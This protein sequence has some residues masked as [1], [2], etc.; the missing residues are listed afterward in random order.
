[1]R[2]ALV[3]LT[4]R[5]AGIREPARWE[6]ISRPWSARRAVASLSASSGGRRWSTMRRVMTI[7]SPRSASSNCCSAALSCSQPNTLMRAP[8]ICL[9]G[10]SRWAR[11]AATEAR[12]EAG[13]RVAP[14]T[15]TAISGRPGT[16]TTVVLCTLERSS[17]PAVSTH[18]PA[19]SGGLRRCA[20]M[21]RG[22]VA[23]RAHLA[24]FVLQVKWDTVSHQRR[25]PSVRDLSIL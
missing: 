9:A 19:T 12:R 13:P 18:A 3:R 7:G 1:M 22:H 23:W 16:T 15:Q 10:T 21:A 14:L 11:S 24:Q 17:R 6:S 2:S 5:A 8:C 20:L 25:T 4:P